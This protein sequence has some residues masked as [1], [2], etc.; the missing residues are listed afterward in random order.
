MANLDP[1][2]N[3]I[4]RLYNRV[5]AVINSCETLD[6]LETAEKYA[7]LAIRIWVTKYPESSLLAQRHRNMV[8][9]T[10]NHV[11]DLIKIRRIKIR[12]Y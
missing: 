3:D 2:V 8:N 9:N 11:E 10:V 7:M 5:A 12:K 4:R 6:Q 1:I